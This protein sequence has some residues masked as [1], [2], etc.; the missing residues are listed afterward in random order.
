MSEHGGD[1]MVAGR[2]LQHYRGNMKDLCGIGITQYHY[3]AGGYMR[4]YPDDNIFIE[5]NT[6][7]YT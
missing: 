7:I 3:S 4:T 2:K 6:H 1:E 5:L